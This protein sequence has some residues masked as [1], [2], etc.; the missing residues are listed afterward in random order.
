[1]KHFPA[2]EH[3]VYEHAALRRSVIPT[4]GQLFKEVQQM[5][6]VV[7]SYQEFLQFECWSADPN[8]QPA[9]FQCEGLGGFFTAIRITDV[10]ILQGSQFLFD[11]QLI[12]PLSD[13]SPQNADPG[14]FPNPETAATLLLDPSK[15]F[16]FQGSGFAPMLL[17]RDVFVAGQFPRPEVGEPTTLGYQASPGDTVV[18]QPSG[19]VPVP[20]QNV[21]T[22]ADL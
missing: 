7:I 8:A 20:G 3:Y 21:A 15:G 12:F 18:F 10:E 11:P 9:F 6:F 14:L 22:F 4:R 2:L 5:S 1:M 19:P 16:T 13:Q 17:V